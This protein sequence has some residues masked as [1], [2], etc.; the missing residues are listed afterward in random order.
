MWAAAEGRSN[1]GIPQHVG[2]EFVKA[3][4]AGKPELGD[5]NEYEAMEAVR[6][7]ELPSPTKYGDF[8]L[9]DMRVT[10]TGAAYRTQHDEYAFRDPEV[11]LN[12]EFLERCKSLPVIFDHPENGLLNSEEY[13]ERNLG[14]VALP[15]IK[16]EEVWGIAKIYDEDAA[17]LMQTTHRSTSPGVKPPAGSTRE[18]LE[19]GAK[20][21]NEKLPL[22]LD[23]LAVCELGVWDKN[24][25]PEGIRLDSVAAKEQSVTEEERKKIES[26]RDDAM[27]RADAA[28]AKVKEY[29]RKDAEE[30]EKADK[31]RRDAEETER[32]AVEEAEK[33]KADRKNRHDSEKHEGNHDDCSKCDEYDINDKKKK[34]P[35]GGFGRG[36]WNHDESEEERG[37]AASVQT[38]NANQLEELK[39]SQRNDSKRIDELM[40]EIALL[41]K[42]PSHDDANAISAAFHRAD[43]TYQMLGERAPMHMPGETPTNY[44]RRLADGLRKHSQQWS[45]E[46]IPDS[47]PNVAFKII[48]DAIYNDAVTAAKSSTFNDSA[49]G[50]LREVTEQQFGKTKT[51]FVGDPRAAWIPFM[52]AV[53]RFSRMPT[54]QKGA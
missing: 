24:G 6:D 27:K 41:K 21:L 39:D 19:N 2:A 12:D 17:N 28:E 3:D 49:S 7:G 42:Q 4:A 51:T 29:E 53:Q 5:L 26:E 33:A 31:A 54:P 8:W 45:S 22:I 15:Y 34:R 9:F 50:R 13:R 23:H 32:K 35:K 40:A 52:P 30:K 46:S 14:N 25:P 37:D 44:R 10:G 16:G 20:V 38:V 11:W 47:L 36:G 1:L 48:E 18:T 43:S